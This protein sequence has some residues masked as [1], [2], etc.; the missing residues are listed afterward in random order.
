MW[1]DSILLRKLPKQSEYSR[2]RCVM[3]LIHGSSPNILK[4]R[5]TLSSIN[6]LATIE[7]TPGY[8]PKESENYK[9]PQIEGNLEF[10]QSNQHIVTEKLKPITVAWVTQSHADIRTE[11]QPELKSPNSKPAPSSSALTCLSSKSPPQGPNSHARIEHQGYQPLLS[12]TNITSLTWDF[13]ISGG[14][15]KEC[16][17]LS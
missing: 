9:I 11:L 13:Y 5:I 15:K 6:I 10:I 3:I 2:C 7:E 4:G 8:S 14:R 1:G 12:K 16:E 17:S